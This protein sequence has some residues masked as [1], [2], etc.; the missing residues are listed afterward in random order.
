VSVE[1]GSGIV[2]ATGAAGNVTMTSIEGLIGTDF[3][4][5]LGG[6]NGSNALYGGAGNDILDGPGGDDFMYGGLGADTVYYNHAVSGVTVNLASTSAQNTGGGGI[7]VLQS[8]ESLYGS[9]YGDTFTGNQLSNTLIGSLGDDTLQGGLGNDLL[10]GGDGI[11]T[12][13]YAAATGDVRV[14]LAITAAQSTLAAGTDTLSGIENLTGGAYNDTLTGDGG[15]NVLT[16]NA[17]NDVLAGG[18]GDDTLYGGAGSDTANYA[19]AATAVTVNLSLTA[20]Q[21]THGAG[22]DTLSSIENITGST[23]DD[24]LTGSAQVNS[25]AGGN[26]NDT[27]DAGSSNDTVDGGSGNDILK[28]AGGDDTLIGGA[29]TDTLTGGAGADTL[30]GGTQADHFVYTA[31]GD[32]TPGAADHITDFAS[33]D[34]LDVSAIDA[35]TTA[36]GNQAFHMAAAFTHSAGE[37]TLAYDAGTNTTTALFDTNGDANAD[38]TILFTGDVTALTGSWLL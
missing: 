10:Y 7:D 31:I 28:G 37:F 14:S 3:G 29:G 22:I 4:D 19:A 8:I 2:H 33:G 13:S 9:D 38:M 34:V 11:D 23:H 25:I 21:D 35:S 32:S 5:Y 17:G 1:A 30:T 18:L 36:A 12:A 6:D 24:I 27:I 26:G 20:A 16:G 15:H